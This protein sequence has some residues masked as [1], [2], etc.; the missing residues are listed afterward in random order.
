MLRGES[1][2]GPLAAAARVPLHP[3]VAPLLDTH[4]AVALPYTEQ[5]EEGLP[6]D[7][8][9]RRLRDFEDLL[10]TGL[11]AQGTVVAHQSVAGVRTL[12]LYVDGRTEAVAAVKARA[13]TWSDGPATVDDQP[14]PAWESVRHLRQ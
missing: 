9:L 3:L 6:R 2:D 12:H 5:S 13:R 14:D 10:E 4:V 1:V 7:G 11:G 8:S